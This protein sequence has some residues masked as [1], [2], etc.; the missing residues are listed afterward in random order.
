MRRT[1]IGITT[2]VFIS[3]IS[4]VVIQLP[5]GD[6]L[7]TWQGA[8][9]GSSGFDIIVTAEEVE[10]LRAIYGLDQPLWR[11]YLTWA[12]NLS[13]GTL[14]FSLDYKIP[15]ATVIRDRMVLTVAL[16]G[17]TVLFTWLLAIPI[18]IYSAVR[19]YSIGDYAFTFLGFLGLAIPD[20]LLAL[21]LMYFA[22]A[23]FDQNVGG[24]FSPD[25]LD[26][27]WSVGRAID[28]LKRL[29]IPA[30]V[31]GTS[32]TA[33][34]I[35]IMRANVLDEIY[36]PYVVTAR[37]KGMS[38]WR[39]ILKYPV[40]VALNPFISTIGYVFPYL[41][42]GSVIVSVV[43]SL[44]TMGPLLWRSLLDQDNQ[45]AGTIIFFVGALTVLGTLISDILLA[46]SDPRI[47]I[48]NT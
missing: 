1:L 14:G 28:L 35:R 43:L 26:A 24:L 11:Q 41:I 9:E 45:M 19:Q 42:S 6:W 40:R 39:I 23:L 48:E 16:A 27:P 34:L 33:A 5:E 21:V 17:F 38:E 7:D 29:W 10:R 31:L 4:F 44:P 25:Y 3:I 13:T 2:L 8:T 46:V 20:F 18:G 36:R 22:F 47:R 15:V 12:K 32:G 37:A 30:L